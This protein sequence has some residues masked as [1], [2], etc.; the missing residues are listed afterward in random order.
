MRQLK[1]HEQKLLKKVNFLQWKSEHNLRELQVM[2]QYHISVSVLKEHSES[3]H[4]SPITS[5]QAPPS[6]TYV[7]QNIFFFFLFCFHPVPSL[8]VRILPH[9]I[10][11]HHSLTMHAKII[12]VSSFYPLLP[13]QDRDDYMKY[14]KICGSIT[15]LVSV[16]RKLDARDEERIEMTESL[17]NKLYDMGV[18]P[19]KKS[20]AQLEQLSTAAFC[21][22]RVAVVMVRLKM[23]ETVREA[24]TFVEQGHVRVG[25][26]TITDP[27][28]HVTRS[29]E[30]FVTWVDT[31]KIKRK[32]QKYNDKLDDF[33]LLN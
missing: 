24:C 21:R 33:D 28:F 4:F 18:I 3:L 10:L 12:P 15:K 13:P 1:H 23:A 26:D 7:A 17:L 9:A 11:S 2:R 8:T 16:L 19:M 30:D 5:K 27:A 32:V 6:A 20:L 14:N 25:P 22:R 31:S 29:M